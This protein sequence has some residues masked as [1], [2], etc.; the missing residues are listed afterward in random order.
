MIAAGWVCGLFD[1][2]W[3]CFSYQ[4]GE[5]LCMY[6]RFVGIHVYRFVSFAKVQLRK[7]SLGESGPAQVLVP[8][9]KGDLSFYM[10]SEELKV[11]VPMS[12]AIMRKLSAKA[13]LL[14]L[15][16]MNSIP[17]QNHTLC[18]LTTFSSSQEDPGR[19]PGVC[20][21]FLSLSLSILLLF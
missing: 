14:S 17:S 9:L 5:D 1:L 10:E 21:I 6:E 11:C 15:L 8:T 7:P 19:S 2:S 12:L 4:V 13:C 3:P 20:V 18:I 16:R